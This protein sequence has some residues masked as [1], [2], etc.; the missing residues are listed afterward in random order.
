MS[1]F[2]ST[3]Y[4][5]EITPGVGVESMLFHIMRMCSLLRTIFYGIK[6]VPLTTQAAMNIGPRDAR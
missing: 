5:F 3:P 2:V 1:I 6:V 4:F